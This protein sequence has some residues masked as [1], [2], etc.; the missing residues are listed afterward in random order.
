MCKRWGVRGSAGEEAG[1]NQQLLCPAEPTWPQASLMEGALSSHLEQ[2]I[3]GGRPGQLGS[4]TGPSWLSCLSSTQPRPI[5]LWCPQGPWVLS[6]SRGCSVVLGRGQVTA[7]RC[8]CWRE[9]LSAGDGEPVGGGGGEQHSDSLHTA[10]S[11]CSGSFLLLSGTSE[12]RPAKL[13]P[14]FSLC[15][16]NQGGPCGSQRSHQ[17]QQLLLGLTRAALAWWGEGPEGPKPE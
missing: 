12:G 13:A 8:T 3:Q 17:A 4:R 11:F 10:R 6:L 15:L 9:H 5:P 7:D 1:E 2:Q 16:G 14:L